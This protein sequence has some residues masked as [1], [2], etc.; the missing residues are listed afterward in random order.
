MI[1][2]Q[3]Y[4]FVRG[5]FSRGGWGSKHAGLQAPQPL[6]T[7][8]SKDEC[9]FCKQLYTSPLAQQLSMMVSSTFWWYHVI[10]GTKSSD[11]SSLRIGKPHKTGMILRT[12]KRQTA[13]YHPSIGGSNDPYG[14]SCG[15]RTTLVTKT[16]LHKNHPNCSMSGIFTYI[17]LRS[18]VN[19]NVGKY[20]IHGAYRCFRK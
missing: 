13:K 3:S 1:R 6:A 2:T 9:P 11:L 18:M 4:L 12:Q 16:Y 10:S 7:Y 20:S 5:P 8:P 15:F 19:V 17:W 14:L